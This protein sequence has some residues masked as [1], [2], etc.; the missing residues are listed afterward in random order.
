MNWKRFLIGL[1]V[2][3]IG[4]SSFGAFTTAW[5]PGGPSYD[6][7]FWKKTTGV[8][9]RWAVEVEDRL[10]GT[11]ANTGM[12][13]TS[14]IIT[15]SVEVFDAND[16]LTAAETGKVCVTE[17][18]G[19]A[20]NIIFTLPPAA[21][22]L[23]YTFVDGNATAADDLWITAGTGDTINGGT[24]AKSFKNTGD[25]VNASVVFVAQS[26]VDWVAMPSSIGTWANDNN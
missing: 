24:A 20:A 26:A 8:G 21:A 12:K 17:G 15:A 19:T 2:L 9:E 22:G 4:V 25:V 10:D 5:V 6:S 11:T 16:T 18:H 13:L 7:T 1:A 14:S 3:L 23:T